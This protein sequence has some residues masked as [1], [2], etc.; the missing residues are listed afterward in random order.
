MSMQ[1]VIEIWTGSTWSNIFDDIIKHDTYKI[2]PSARQDVDSYRDANGYLHRNTVEH[3]ATTITFTVIPLQKARMYQ[4]MSRLYSWAEKP[5]M[6]YRIRY[7]N[8]LKGGQVDTGYFYLGANHPTFQ[9]YWAIND[10]DT[11]LYNDMEFKFI[12]Y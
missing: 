11:I 8:P 5:E 9:I 1:T 2:L 6:K 7:V 12:E 4:L 3:T 10:A